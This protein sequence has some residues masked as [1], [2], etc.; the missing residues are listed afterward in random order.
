MAGMTR[1]L[2]PLQA[3]SFDLLVVGGGIHGLFT[4]YDA[5][6]RGL[7]VA[8]VE[9]GDVGGGISFNHQRTI[10][11]GLRA[12]QSGRIRKCR[13]QIRER[14][15]WAR[16]A[17]HLLRPLPFLIG[18]YRG[19]RRARLVIRAGFRLYDFIGRS[20]NVDV[21]PELHLPNGRLE[22]AAATRR[23]FPGVHEPGLS[24]GAIWYD[25]QT[26]HPD[27]LTYL[28][29][30]A[31]HRAGAT[32]AT[33]VEAIAPRRDGAGLTGATVRDV[34]TGT[35]FDITARAVVLAAGSGLPALHERFGVTGAPP[36]V[37]AMNLLLDRPA[38]DIALAAPSAS[39]HMFTAV[40]WRGLVLVGTYQPDGAV[41]ERVREPLDPFVD[42][43][44]AEIRTAFPALGATRDDIRFVHHALVPA[45]ST[46]QGLDLLAEPEILTH[47]EAPGLLSLVGVKYT[48][49][50]LAAERAVDGV[51][52]HLHLPA[53]RSRTATTLLPHADVADSDG[54]L[55]ETARTLRVTLDGDVHRH[56]AGWYGTE[57]SAVLRCAHASGALARVSADSPVIEGEAIY[58]VREAAAV[59]LDDVV[60][61]RTPLGSAGGPGDDA[62][63]RLAGIMA[64]ECGWTDARRVEEIT[65]VRERV[66]GYGTH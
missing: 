64:R 39:G 7:R 31:A 26:V 44:L 58:A 11:G 29:A 62:I 46:P 32:L 50:R 49:A 12:L 63:A 28:V 60:F 42:A 18:T 3:D 24:G 20:R 33:Y 53:V 54:I 36:L 37:R 59:L 48:T 27:R 16:I 14:R 5:A 66:R 1:D 40:P 13:E 47:V 61:R 65:L 51:A 10:H 41:P 43:F 17:P 56:L 9:R 4:A 23:L 2:A 55:V 52:R 19:T 45:Q 30:L 38:K 15:A 34:I 25:Y 35:S 8:L 22:S 6:A 57:A 21:L